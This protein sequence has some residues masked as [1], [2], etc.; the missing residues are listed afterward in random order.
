M[1]EDAPLEPVAPEPA[2]P[3]GSTDPTEPVPTAAAAAAAG[4]APWPT[5][6]PVAPAPPSPPRSN[7][8]AVPKWLVFVV[9][10]VV[11]ALLGFAIGW[12]AA[13]G[14]DSTT[15]RFPN[16]GFFNGPNAPDNGSNG[17]FGPGG[18]AANGG[19]ARRQPTTPSA[20]QQSGAFLGVATD[21]STKPAGARILRVV[22][23]SP[24]AE[25]GLK[26]NDVITKVDGATVSS[27]QQ[28]GNRIS[29]HQDGDRVT[30]TYVRG[31]TTDTASVTLASRSSLDIPTPS[32]T[33]PGL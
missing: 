3:A 29:A 5:S 11:F 4:T 30:I 20:P 18:G 17:F 28:L 7:T 13:P 14:G 32:T 24:A 26:A 22:A 33:Q 19:G 15:V 16:R 21:A 23:G 6:P 9:G 25:G 10:A 27:P 8:V 1:T 31:G 12:V 2:P